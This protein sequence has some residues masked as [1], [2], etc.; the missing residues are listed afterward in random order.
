[1]ATTPKLPDPSSTATIAADQEPTASPVM[2]LLARG[3]PLALLCDLVS[4]ADP[5]SLAIN[6]AE[7]PAGDT[8]WLEAAET[9]QARF[10]A[11]SA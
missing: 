8:I 6:S 4:R 11:A 10:R 9:L 1:M 2:R 7:R 3:V 5:G